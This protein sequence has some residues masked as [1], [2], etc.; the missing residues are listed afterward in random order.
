MS[1]FSRLLI[2]FVGTAA[3]SGCDNPA[4]DAYNAS[5][6][7]C[8]AKFP[9]IKGRTVAGAQCLHDV[10]FAQGPAAFSGSWL[11]YLYAY[12][13]FRMEKAKAVDAGALSPEAYTAQLDNFWSNLMSQDF[14]RRT[15]QIR[16][17]TA[18]IAYSSAYLNGNRDGQ[19][20]RSKAR[21]AVPPIFIPD[22]DRLNRSM[23]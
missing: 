14:Q 9:V 20:R 22:C 21:K 23:M 5:S 1:R 3:L 11:T 10:V 16:C 4:E 17:R 13:N 7:A 6:K 19:T 18:R 15:A 8:A 12:D 2:I